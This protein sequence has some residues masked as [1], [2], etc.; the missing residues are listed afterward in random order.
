MKK[1]LVVAIALA[2]LMSEPANAIMVCTSSDDGNDD[3]GVPPTETSVTW[4][5]GQ[6]VPSLN[7]GPEQDVACAANGLERLAIQSKFTG[8]PM[9]TKGSGTVIWRGDNARFILDNL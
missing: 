6:E 2:W 4:Y 9:V 8:L 5:V 7:T 3:V 1:A